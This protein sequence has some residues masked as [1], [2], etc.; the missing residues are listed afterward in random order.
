MVVKYGD[1]DG[2]GKENKDDRDDSDGGGKDDRD[3]DNKD[4]RDDDGKEV[5]EM[6]LWGPGFD[7]QLSLSWNPFV[8]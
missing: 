5:T 4:D 1:R 6:G 3:G 7:R 8:N 2:S